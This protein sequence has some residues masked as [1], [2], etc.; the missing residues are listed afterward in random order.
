MATLVVSMLIFE[1]TI[2]KTMIPAR[3]IRDDMALNHPASY[4]SVDK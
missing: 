1:K 3:A 4:K 2:G